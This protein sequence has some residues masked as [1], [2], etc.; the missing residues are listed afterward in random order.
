MIKFSYITILI[1]GDLRS[2][3]MMEE[4]RVDV[5]K[6][7][8]EQIEVRDDWFVVASLHLSITSHLWHLFLTIYDI[9]THLY[10]YEKL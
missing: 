1:A 5:R 6:F 10:W 2:I 7:D 9:L 8:R 4:Q 3:I